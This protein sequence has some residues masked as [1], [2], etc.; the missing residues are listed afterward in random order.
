MYEK[1]KS[2]YLLM[3]TASENEDIDTELLETSHLAGMQ[4]TIVNIFRLSLTTKMLPK[5][6][7][8]WKSQLICSSITNLH[9]NV[10]NFYSSIWL[11]YLSID[12][13]LNDNIQ[14]NTTF[15]FSFPFRLIFLSIDFFSICKYTYV[16]HTIF[17]FYF[18]V[19]LR[20]RSIDIFLNI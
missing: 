14:I 20:L 11:R 16:L 18:L 2:E 9:S 3:F 8:S 7:F 10:C 13:F 12:V 19:G 17:H 5:V 1:C 4:I 6:M 15:H